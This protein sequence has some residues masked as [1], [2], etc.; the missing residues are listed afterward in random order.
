MAIGIV[1]SMKARMVFFASAAIVVS[2]AVA[3]VTC[4]SMVKRDLLRQAEVSQQ[5]RMKILRTLLDMKGSEFQLRDGNLLIGQHELNGKYEVVDEVKRLV[6]GTATIFMGDTR[7]STNVTKE[8][9]TRAVGTKLQ[10]P[11]YDAVF[12]K[13]EPFAGETKILGTPFFTRY[14]PIRDSSGKTIGV[15]Y[16]GEKKSEFFSS[17]DRVRFFA[18]AVGVLLALLFGSLAFWAVHRMIRPLDSASEMVSRFAQGDLT[19]KMDAGAAD[20]TEV[21]RIVDALDDL[22]ERLRSTFGKMAGW[23]HDLASAA[24]QLSSTTTRIHE[25]NRRV[26]GETESVASA[27]EEMSATV[28]QVAENTHSVQDASEMAMEA[29]SGG[30]VAVDSFLGAM[31]EIRNVVDRA[32]GTVE[33]LGSR[34]KEIGGVIDLINEIADQTN[35]LALNAAIEAAR[36]GEHGRGFSVVADE[37]RKLAENTQKATAQIS[38]AIGAVQE[39]SRGAVEAMRMGKEAVIRSAELG[40]QAKSAMARIGERVRNSSDQNRQIAVATEELSVTIRDF[41][42]NIEKV[43]QAVSQNAEGVSEIANTAG[44]VAR[45]AEELKGSVSEFRCR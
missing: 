17:Y 18:V 11:A 26:S 23:S 27:S 29:T 4:L 31:S 30:A 13:G 34:A 8:D 1:K 42:A 45:K 16:V 40:E 15:L 32:S 22:G 9:G 41:S 24:E 35:L 7:V 20:T 25:A 10:G 2:V 37:V 21:R 3:T 19:A 43:S 14:E 28:G 12:A 39:E 5:N 44:M 36:A 38:K 33:A 6:G